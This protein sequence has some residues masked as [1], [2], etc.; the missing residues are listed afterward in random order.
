MDDWLEQGA[1]EEA[2]VFNF[3]SY[4]GESGVLLWGESYVGVGVLV[5]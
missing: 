1:A 2:G 5:H 4:L 3:G